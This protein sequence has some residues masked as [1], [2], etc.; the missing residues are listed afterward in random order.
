MVYLF[1][2]SLIADKGHSRWGAIIFTQ[3]FNFLGNVILALWNVPESAKWFAFM[4]QYFGWA[5]APVLYSWQNDICRRDAQARA[6]VLVVMNILAQSSTAWISVLVWKTVEQPRYLKGFTFT[7]VA[8]FCLSAWT[9]VVL[10][11]YKHE[12]RRNAKLNGIILYNSKTG[13]NNPPS[14]DSI[15]SSGQ[16]LV[17]KHSLHQSNLIEPFT[18]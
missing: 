16:S 5:M 3:V 9:F 4:L 13:E 15:I 11:F 14:K 1:I 7:A 18:L 6:V 17:D 8:S 10:Y 2:T 12:E